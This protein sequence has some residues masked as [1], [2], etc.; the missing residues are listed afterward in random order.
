MIVYKVFL[1]FFCF[2]L[3][4]WHALNGICTDVTWLHK[5]DF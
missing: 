1:F 4:A 5:T 2:V 3:E